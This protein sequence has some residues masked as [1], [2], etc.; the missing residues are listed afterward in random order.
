[1]VEKAVLSILE[2]SYENFELIFVDAQSGDSTLGILDGLKKMESSFPNCKRFEIVSQEADSP[3]AGR[4]I[5]VNIAHGTILAF[6]D[7]DC[8]ADKDWLDN[9]VRIMDVHKASMIGGPSDLS[10]ANQSR[11]LSVMDRVLGSFLGSGGSAQFM[12]ISETKTVSAIPS[13]NMG[14]KRDL[15]EKAN[16]FD[17]SMR[18][19]EDSDLCMR[20]RNSGQEITYSPD[21]RV[22]HYMG[23]DS[24]GDLRGLISK[25]GLERAK[26]VRKNPRLVTTFNL[27]SIGMIL[28]LSGLVATSFFSEVSQWLL[29]ATSLLVFSIVLLES[30]RVSLK[31]RSLYSLGAAICIFFA[32]LITYNYG[33]LK[34][35]L[36]IR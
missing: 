10:R 32:I 11:F 33:F 29:L 9:M 1:M 7:A 30:I 15:F 26:N 28:W 36:G 21:V 2:Q 8:V 3:A 35:C 17:E 22:Y 23:L 18:Y 24:F 25:Y 6:T 12:Q 14:I 27:L 5:G 19:N 4:N 34:G 13:C 31:E 20:I 16:G